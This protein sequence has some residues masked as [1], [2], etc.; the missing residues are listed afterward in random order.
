MSTPCA[1]RAR[2]TPGRCRTRRTCPRRCATCCAVR[3][4]GDAE[5]A[6][7]EAVEPRLGELIEAV[8]ARA[9]HA[10]IIITDYVELLPRNGAGC[11][12]VPLN[13]HEAQVI[14]A[15]QLRAN[16]AIKHAAQRTGAT[17][18]SIS[19]DSRG[20]NACPAQPWVNGYQFGDFTVVGL[21]VYRPQLV[22]H[23]AIA[24]LAPAT[25]S[26][27]QRTQ[28]KP[29]EDRHRPR[30]AI[31]LDGTWR[32]EDFA[33]AWTTRSSRPPAVRMIFGRVVAARTRRVPPR[34]GRQGLRHSLSYLVTRHFLLSG[35]RSPTTL[36]ESQG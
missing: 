12:V 1:Y 16:L 15:Q 34:P 11:A 20:H 3:S 32:D 18:L 19:R 21:D 7:A 9:P 22:A 23:E 14:I 6:L 4:T 36:M 31:V 5:R 27:T 26:R 13:R 33:W 10:C 8:Q 24:E 35:S 28:T 2:T 30:Q 25:C 17:L 29:D